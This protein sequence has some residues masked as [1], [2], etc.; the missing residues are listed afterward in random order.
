LQGRPAQRKMGNS[1]SKI[2]KAKKAGGM[3]YVVENLPSKHKPLNSN[4]VA[5][6]RKLNR[7]L[8]YDPEI[9]LLG[10]YPRDLKTYAYTKTCSQ[11]FIAL[12]IRAKNV[13][14][15]NA[16]QLMSGEI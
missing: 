2:T 11:I 14:N 7:E 5:P 15:S 13:N 3:A 8:S 10:T 12:L 4:L 16:H 1:I 9:S 6:K